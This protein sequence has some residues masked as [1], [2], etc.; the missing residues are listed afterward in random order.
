M[1]DCCS[2][3]VPAELRCDETLLDVL[4]RSRAT[5]AV[6]TGVPP[7]DE[8]LNSEG[9]AGGSVGTTGLY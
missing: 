4:V 7:L 6:S 1:F 3:A 5:A 8:I 2:D 9:R